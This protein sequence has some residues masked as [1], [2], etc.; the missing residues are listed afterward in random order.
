M[1]VAAALCGTPPAAGLAASA[2]APAEFLDF[3]RRHC[4]Q[5]IVYARLRSRPDWECWPPLVRDELVRETR[6]QAAV[7]ACREAA[8]REALAA[9]VAHGVAPLVIKGTA[10]AYSHYPQ[11]ACRPRDDTDLLLR[12]C[13]RATAAAAL[14]GLG[15]AP[16]NGVS[17]ELIS[18]QQM[19]VKPISGQLSHVLDVHWRVLNPQRFAGL[20]SYDEIAAA[21]VP[22]PALGPGARAPAAVHALL[23]ACVH[24]LAHHQDGDRLLWL[25]D[26][27]LLAAGLSP[28]EHD[29]LVRLAAEKGVARLC[30]AGL[31]A[32][33][34]WCGPVLPEAQLHA[35]AELAAQEPS[36][37][38]LHAGARRWHLLRS[39]LAALDGWR[40]RLRLLR[41]H[42]FPPAAYMLRRYGISR[43][44][45]LPLLYV[46][47]AL[48][49]ATK[50]L[51][52]MAAPST[53]GL[54]KHQEKF[55]SATG[56]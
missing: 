52:P 55:R 29:E 46:H 32:A 10:L 6:R 43:R 50:L 41:E 31:S 54:S 9:L 33:A 38:F 11:P 1:L 39:D 2:A 44:W 24:R 4:L 42:L 7:D 16:M 3:T 21:A 34:R 28:A 13:D 26:I 48:S 23:L 25:Y 36:E 17:G 14:A 15:Y 8:V 27:H 37:G 22:L 35:L 20:F 49:G 47:R 12:A 51:R 45:V 19:F 18:Y 5:P 30:V 53:S 56:H 40:L